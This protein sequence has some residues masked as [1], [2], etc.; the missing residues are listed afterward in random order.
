LIKY[1]L[2]IFMI[3]MRPEAKAFSPHK[4]TPPFESDGSQSREWGLVCCASHQHIYHSALPSVHTHKMMASLL[5]QSPEQ[6]NAREEDMD[7]LV[8]SSPKAPAAAIPSYKAAFLQSC[9]SAHVLT[10]GTFTLKSGRVS[11]YFFNAGLFHQGSL[12]RSISTAFAQTLIHHRTLNP[13][14]EFDVLF[15]PAYK[16][17]CIDDPFK[18]E[19]A[20]KQVGSRYTVGCIHNGQTCRFR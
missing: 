7:N 4:A 8:P 12:L 13:G 14:F 3:R 19:A 18:S 5:P 16:G 1:L 6:H 17:R 15:G 2:E 10:F 9:L 20:V 11:P